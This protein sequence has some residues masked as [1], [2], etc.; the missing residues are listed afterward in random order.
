MPLSATLRTGT[1]PRLPSRAIRNQ[2]QWDACFPCAIA[3][4]LEGRSPAVP[5]LS[6]AFFMYYA[7]EGAAALGGLTI[8]RT[9][10]M[11]NTRG[12][13]SQALCDHAVASGTPSNE[14]SPTARND[15]FRRRT[16]SD[17]DGQPWFELVRGPSRES[18]WIRELRNGFPI[19]AR[20]WQNPGYRLLRLSGRLSVWRDPSPGGPSH[21]V[22]ILGMDSAER[23]FIVQD[24]QGEAFGDNGNWYMPFN[25]SESAAVLDSYVFRTPVRNL[26][27][28]P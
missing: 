21:A 2:A 19:L 27:T 10:L 12:I 4:A 7:F 1:D 14:P 5:E 26:G 9:R 8:E 16:Q 20:I 25:Q 13:S 18:A 3:A 17:W 24:S 22:A 6:P 15:G 23:M 28:A 11:M